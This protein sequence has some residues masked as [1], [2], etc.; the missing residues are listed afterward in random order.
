MLSFINS[1]LIGVGSDDASNSSSMKLFE[2]T[3]KLCEQLINYGSEIGFQFSIL[4]IGGGFSGHPH[5]QEGL[6]E[7]SGTINTCVDELAIKYPH[8]NRIIAEPGIYNYYFGLS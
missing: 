3:F 2:D 6:T 5:L 8:L 4:D 7:L 1:F